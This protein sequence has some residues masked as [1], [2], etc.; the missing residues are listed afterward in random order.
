MWLRSIDFVSGTK[1]SVT[2]RSKASSKRQH[3]QSVLPMIVRSKLFFLVFLVG[4][5]LL[6]STVGPASALLF[7][8]T[9]L[10]IKASSTHFY[11]NGLE[12]DLW[13]STLTQNHTGPT[14]CG[15]SPLRMDFNSC[16]HASWRV[17]LGGVTALT[18]IR[19]GFNF[20]VPGGSAWIFPPANL[21]T[22]NIGIPELNY[23]AGDP[24]TWAVAPH[25]GVTSH[26]AYLTEQTVH[27]FS[28]AKGWRRRLRDFVES[29]LAFTTGGKFPITRTLCGDRTTISG[30]LTK[31]S[32]PVV[33]EN[34]SWRARLPHGT[35]PTI[36]LDIKDLNLTDWDALHSSENTTLQYRAKWFPLPSN[37]GSGSAMMIQL[38]Q[39]HAT[40]Y[41]SACVIDAR[42]A[43]GQTV[44]SDRSFTWSWESQ[45]GYQEFE[46]LS[47]LPEW[48]FERASMFDSR[49]TPYYSRP[50]KVQQPWLNALTP[51]MPE[52]SAPGNELVMTSFEALLNQSGLLMATG[53]DV[54]Y[55]KTMLEYVHRNPLL[56][57]IRGCR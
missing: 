21:I 14:Q 10:W 26:M 16:L 51:P 36:D 43:E 13:P 54:E 25:L 41:A 17:L 39:D 1:S 42:W 40:I 29:R 53:R 24:D 12:N 57:F 37:I 34:R 8:P 22:G 35:G 19:P 31:I 45:P 23:T 33:N 2:N 55:G 44:Q 7:L 27:S 38:L 48:H 18:P 4:S 6:A 3:V 52:A 32:V 49:H 20:Y 47:S 28:L 50:I 11:L 46:P 9:Q 15:F 30:P 5:T 56:H